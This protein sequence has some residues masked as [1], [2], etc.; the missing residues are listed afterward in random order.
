M[1]HSH[2]TVPVSPTGAQRIAILEAAQG[3]DER[4][5]ALVDDAVSSPTPA[6]RATALSALDLQDRL[7][8][9]RLGA[10][11]GDA[12]PAVRRRAAQ[13]S[14]GPRL[15][16][17]PSVTAALLTAVD[18][19]DVFVAVAVLVALGERADPSA[20]DAVTSVAVSSSAPLVVEEAVA[21]LGALGDEASIDVIEELLGTA[22]PALR[23]RIVAALGA[24]SGP[25]VEVMLEQLERD[26][27]W[28]V[29][30]AV[31][32]LRRGD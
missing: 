27:D 26:R 15:R 28:Q 32:M 12:D 5:L 10:A 9:A 18:D 7:D 4:S 6:L 16:D 11:L 21:T 24:F 3:R 23:R 20:L 8:A 30:Q 1:G 14:F 13:L 2:D 22:K 19:A 17:D 25:K 29:R 31:A